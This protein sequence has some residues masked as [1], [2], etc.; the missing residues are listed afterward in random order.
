M[1]KFVFFVLLGVAVYLWLRG[2]RMSKSASRMPP[3]GQA[4]VEPMVRCAYCGL[5][6]PKSESSS[7]DGRYYCGDE[8]R[9]LAGGKA[10]G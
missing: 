3:P 9:R 2:K 10:E 5:N 4:E 1:S 8:H 6:V 7:A